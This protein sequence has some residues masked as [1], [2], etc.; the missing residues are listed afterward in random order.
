MTTT[1]VV[2]SSLP[3]PTL[4][5]SVVATV[6]IDGRSMNLVRADA[7]PPGV[8]VDLLPAPATEPRRPL[9]PGTSCA[10]VPALHDSSVQAI[11]LLGSAEGVIFGTALAE[12]DAITAVL[13]D[14]TAVSG[15]IAKGVWVVALEAK[16]VHK[17]TVNKSERLLATC[18]V[19]RGQKFTVGDV[20]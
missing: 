2:G 7:S 16:T 9:G 10:P 13:D 11:E 19:S 14:D 12:A 6:E 15:T 3:R 8:C 5:W 17:L 4:P 20:C 18:T 1:S